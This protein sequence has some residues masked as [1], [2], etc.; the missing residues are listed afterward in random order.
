MLKSS[1]GMPAIQSPAGPVD[2]RAEA[3]RARRRLWPVTIAYSTL[4][5]GVLALGAA[6]A[7]QA[8]VP[9]AAFASGL[10]LW[11]PLEY[12]AHR[13]VLH[14][15]FPDGPGVQGWLHRTFDNLHTEHH[16]RPWDGNHINGTIH[17]T[18][19]YVLLVALLSLAA[20]LHTLPVLWA[21]V[22]QGYVLEEWVHHG[23]HF[24]SVYRLK[25]AYWRY[26]CRHHAYHHSPRGSELA[27]GLT[28]GAWDVVFGT[29]IPAP[30]RARLHRRLAKPQLVI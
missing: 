30:D 3:R 13:C 8:S 24:A 2:L 15:R 5:L 1:A 6:V 22:V 20:P 23:V 19:R 4:A 10:A 9:V 25:G 7:P 12:F 17:D 16:A 18:W 21:G 27:F 11:T 29:R 14:R 28:S 26:I